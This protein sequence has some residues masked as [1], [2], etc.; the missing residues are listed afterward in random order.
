MRAGHWCEGRKGGL[1][2]DD[3]LLGLSI[4][5]KVRELRLAVSH[6]VWLDSV[7]PAVST[8]INRTMHLECAAMLQQQLHRCSA[9]ESNS[10]CQCYAQSGNTLTALPDKEIFTKWLVQDIR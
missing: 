7:A 10:A 8:R 5:G 2:A 6:M 3:G 4:F 1:T 9:G